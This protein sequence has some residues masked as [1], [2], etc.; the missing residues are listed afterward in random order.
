[1]KKGTLEDFKLKFKT[2]VNFVRHKLVPK[3][4][5]YVIC[6]VYVML[7]ICYVM[8]MLCY[9]YVIPRV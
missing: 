1:M 9:V 3:L 4:M 7:C 6:Y 8:H 2:R 5:R